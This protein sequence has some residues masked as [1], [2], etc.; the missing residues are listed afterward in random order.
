[1]TILGHKSASTSMIY[2]R[3]SDPEVRRQYEEALA[4]GN[5]IAGP[6][7]VT[8]R[9]TW[10]FVRQDTICRAVPY[11]P[12]RCFSGA[13]TMP[14]DRVGGWD[15][16][17]GLANIHSLVVRRPGQPGVDLRDRAAVEGGNEQQAGKNV[18]A[19]RVEVDICLGVRATGASGEASERPSNAVAAVHPFPVGSVSLF[20]GAGTGD[21]GPWRSRGCVRWPRAPRRAGSGCSS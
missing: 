11:T 17:V 5:R 8:H 7:G 19:G 10:R 6:C 15:E 13:L 21:A 18:L 20:A 14:T 3:I 9:A 4:S 12:P 16:A 1:M 2:S